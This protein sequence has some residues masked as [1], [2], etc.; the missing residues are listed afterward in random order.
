MAK[1]KNFLFD[2]GDKALFGARDLHQ[3]LLCTSH[4]SGRTRLQTVRVLR[5][6]HACPNRIFIDAVRIFME[7]L[8]IT[9]EQAGE[10]LAVSRST[11]YR[12]VK[13]GDLVVI[14]IGAA[15]RIPVKS[16]RRFVDRQEREA[17]FELGVRL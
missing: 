6:Q 5:S 1:L 13:R 15:P 17:R 2:I 12:M 4:N 9:L 16:L 3:V 14:Y 10:A 11:I 8:A 7:R